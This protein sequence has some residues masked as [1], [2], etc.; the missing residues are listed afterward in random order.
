MSDL[1]LPALKFGV[2]GLLATGAHV[3]VFLLCVRL[4]KASPTAATVPAFLTAVLISY[5]LNHSW[6]FGARG[7]HLRFFSRYLTIALI[8]LALNAGIMYVCTAVLHQSY[9]LGLALVI[10]I[11]PASNFLGN[12]YW[13]FR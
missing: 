6:T 8:G 12:K 10:T 7:R 11:V 5:C 9:Y 2:V 13:G 3:T 1:V 4:A